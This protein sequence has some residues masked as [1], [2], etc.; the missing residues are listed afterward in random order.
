MSPWPN[1]KNQRSLY[2]QRKLRPKKETIVRCQWHKPVIPA[3]REAEIRR[4]AV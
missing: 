2:F 1:N 3:T 4:I